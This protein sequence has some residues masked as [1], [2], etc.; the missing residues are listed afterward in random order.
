MTPAA[1]AAVLTRGPAA[2]PADVDHDLV[3]DDP[4]GIAS[5]TVDAVAISPPPTAVLTRGRRLRSAAPRVLLRLSGLVA[6]LV[7]WQV[8]TTRG[9]TGNKLP[10]PA[11]VWQAFGDLLRTGS[12][13]HHLLVSLGRVLKGL[14][15]GVGIG[16]TLGIVTGLFRVGEYLLDAPL[17]AL[18]MLPPLA[19]T[20][21]F[22]IWLGIGETSKVGLIS[23]ATFFP[24]YLN[25][26]HGIRNVDDRFVEAATSFGLG[27]WALIRTV[28]LPG[29]LPSVLVGL[30]QS[31]G[32]AWL[33]LVVAEQIK[34]EAGIGYLMTDARE[35]LRT[36][37]IFVVLFVYALLGLVSDLL[38]RGLERRFLSWRRTFNGS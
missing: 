8:A 5:T 36:D 15:I 37:V 21:L 9:W 4:P 23:L 6:V 14:A 3:V 31:F 32:I 33:V 26:F 28:V 16:L 17:Q 25:T 12:L 38:V 7:L 2:P 18:R 34:A 22:I 27:R 20:S 10:A 24:V 1:P 35:F 29:A 30:R 13:G 19:L 11:A